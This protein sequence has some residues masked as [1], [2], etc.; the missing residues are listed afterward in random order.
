MCKKLFC[1]ITIT[2]ALALSNGYAQEIAWN[3]AAYWDGA[4]PGA[5]G[6]GGEGMRDALEAAGYT[7]LD[8]EALKTWMDDRIADR[9]LSVVV[10]CKD[11]VPDTVGETM[12]VDCTV[13]RY[14]DAGGKVVW[15]ADWPIYYQ[16]HDDGS[17]DTWGSAGATSVL[18]FNASTNV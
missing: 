4:Y 2:I 10:F 18:G 12:T 1:L 3:R 9:A 15:Y 11:V 8:A 14:L 13:R 5:W 7:I 6:G 16:G 17:M